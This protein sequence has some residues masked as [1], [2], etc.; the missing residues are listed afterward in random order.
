[1]ALTT[2]VK[3]IVTDGSDDALWVRRVTDDAVVRT[4]FARLEGGTKY[5]D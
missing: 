1:M 4:Q 3:R 2:S 5:L